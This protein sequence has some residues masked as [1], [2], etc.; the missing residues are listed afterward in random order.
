M[1]RLALALLLLS[2]AGPALAQGV[3]PTLKIS[4]GSCSITASIVSGTSGT[5]IASN[6]SR[7][8]L[9]WMN[10]GAV[11]ITVTPGTT[12]PAAGSGMLYEANNQGAGHQGGGEAFTE[13]SIASNAFAYT[14]ASTATIAVWECQ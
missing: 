2:Y 3:I 14:A 1:R 8:S 11:V 5:L 12:P 7:K 10:V 9:R 13:S 6:P 4:P